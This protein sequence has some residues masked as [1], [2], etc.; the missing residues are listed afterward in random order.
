MVRFLNPFKDY[1]D[2][3]AD[4]DRYGITLNKLPRDLAGKALDLG[5][6]NPFTPILQKTYPELKILN[7]PASIDFDKDP[8]PF[9]DKSFDVVFSF[10]VAEHLMNPLWNLLECKRVLRDNGTIFLTTPKGGFPSTLM[11]PDTHFHEIDE[12]RLG[13]L[14]KSANLRADRIERFNKG[15]LY[16]W[17]MGIIRPT[18]RVFLG[19]W[20]YVEIRKN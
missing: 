3:K 5:V 6:E 2:I 8:L 17:R 16:W 20:F 18:L 10:E 14:L 7:T 11:W 13:V 1:G 19:G 12:K 15:P 4:Y 9:S